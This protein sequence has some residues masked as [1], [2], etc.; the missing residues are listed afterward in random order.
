[1]RAIIAR[2]IQE[3]HAIAIQD[4]LV[5]HEELPEYTHAIWSQKAGKAVNFG[6]HSNCH[7]L[8]CYR[9]LVE[10]SAFFLVLFFSLF[11]N[12]VICPLVLSGD[13]CIAGLIALLFWG[14]CSKIRVF[15]R[16]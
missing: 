2:A 12:F 15:A 1:M 7:S 6:I 9:W 16:P 5:F 3:Y 11:S 8:P 14:G 4:Y 10:L 13:N